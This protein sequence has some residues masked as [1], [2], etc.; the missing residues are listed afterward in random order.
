LGITRQTCFCSGLEVIEVV[1]AIPFAAAMQRVEHLTIAVGTPVTCRDRYDGRL[2]GIELGSVLDRLHYLSAGVVSFARGLNDTPKIAALLLI[3]PA[4]GNFSCT[5]TVGVAMMLGGLLAA[6]RVAELMSRKITP[7][8][9]GQGFTANLLTGLIVIGASN[10][11]LPVSTTH[12]SC[13]ALFGIG[14][15]TG[16]A[17]VR[18]I[19]KILAAWVITLPVALLMGALAFVLVSR[20]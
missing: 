11:G 9:H 10:L 18:T 16:Q 20:L 6:H 12:V 5:L 17:D 2:I 3:L 8:N 4:V 15:V 7:M 1:P 13:G 19:A 14:T